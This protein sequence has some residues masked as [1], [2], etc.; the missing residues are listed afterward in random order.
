M[1]DENSMSAFVTVSG[2]GSIDFD[3]VTARN[4]KLDDLSN[5]NAPSE[6]KDGQGLSWNGQSNEL[7][8]RTPAQGRLQNS[9]NYDE[10]CNDITTCG[11]NGGPSHYGTYDQSGNVYEWI[12]AEGSDPNTICLRG[13]RFVGNNAAVG[14]DADYRHSLSPYSNG[15]GIGFRICTESY[16]ETSDR[17]GL[18]IS[19]STTE[20]GQW[21]SR[22]QNPY[23]NPLNWSSFV[24]VG[25]KENQ[26]DQN[27]PIRVLS[28]YWTVDGTASTILDPQPSNSQA[29][30]D[31]RI[32]LTVE[33][34]FDASSLDPRY[35]YPWGRV[36]YNYM[37][38]KFTVTVEE[39]CEFLNSVARTDSYNLCPTSLNA[40]L[41]N[42]KG[43]N[44]SYEYSPEVGWARA[45]AAGVSYYNALRFINWL[46]NGRP[47][48][49][50]QTDST[51]EDGVYTVKDASGQNLGNDTSNFFKVEKNA[52][53]PNTG[54]RPSYWLPTENEWYKAAYY[55]GDGQN[56]GYWTYATQSDEEP[57]PITRGYY[58]NGAAETPVA[59]HKHHP[60][61]MAF[62]VVQSKIGIVTGASPITN[63][64]SISQ[65]NYDLIANKDPNTLYI[66]T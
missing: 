28:W 46:D 47:T 44:G 14:L 59:H 7:E 34:Y 20:V 18:T 48:G 2:S 42:R 12:D 38:Q 26:P 45:P 6:P 39:Y 3:T 10:V 21:G 62:T 35:G 25:D 23:S 56:S 33:N 27:E 41:I 65:A 13:G 16:G 54:E 55:K 11:T 5:V 29:I 60:E 63:I 52:T 57:N 50:T 32:R 17:D 37:I 1:T 49:G 43:T 22:I 51:T 40:K 31:G 64:I 4:L 9:A 53:N 66:I 30:Q 15:I 8:F 24:F 19:S 36:D 58:K 61:D